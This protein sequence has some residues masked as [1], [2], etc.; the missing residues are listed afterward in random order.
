MHGTSASLRQMQGAQAVCSQAVPRP[1]A[2]LFPARGLCTAAEVI[3]NGLKCSE[4][5]RSV[6]GA[7]SLERRQLLSA[8]VGLLLVAKLSGKT[9]AVWQQSTQLNT[10]ALAA[11]HTAACLH[12]AT[13]S[14]STRQAQCLPWLASCRSMGTGLP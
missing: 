1:F 4:L 7:F 10:V 13:P 6:Q 8:G 9:C 2:V 12:L 11:Q 14:T 5:P 3:Y